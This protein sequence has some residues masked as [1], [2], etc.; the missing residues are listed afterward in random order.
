[1]VAATTRTISL[2]IMVLMLP[3][4]ASAH[5]RVAGSNSVSSWYFDGVTLEDGEASDPVNFMWYGG[6]SDS[7]DYRQSTVEP[8]M[9]DDWDT[10]SVGG[11]GWRE[12]SAITGI[13]KESQVLVFR[14]HPGSTSDN[15]DW[16]G[17]TAKRKQI[18]GRQYHA[19]FWD[20]YEHDRG[21]APP[22][23]AHG[24]RFQWVVG[25]IHR[26]KPKLKF[27]CCVHHVISKDW[28]DVRYDLYQAMD[29]HCGYPRWRYH[30][31]ADRKL[32]GF[33]NFGF[34][35]RISLTHRSAG[36]AGT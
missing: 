28:D 36:C 29:K 3:S 1:M 34:V 33:D 31:G 23:V 11:T 20:D 14:H 17:S 19:R 10:S 13:C 9:R 18:C 4:A 8:H 24:R 15:T 21:T 12:D 26:E 16:H 7:R 32:Q 30:P 27:P 6:A 2:F 5:Y 22:R 25:G 35:A